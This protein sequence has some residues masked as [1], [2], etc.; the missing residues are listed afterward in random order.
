MT[1]MEAVKPATSP[2]ANSVT[3][4]GRLGPVGVPLP[5]AKSPKPELSWQQVVT[6]VAAAAGGAAWVG[7]R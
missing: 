2:Q 1:A 3:A 4:V 7:R 6:A 5:L